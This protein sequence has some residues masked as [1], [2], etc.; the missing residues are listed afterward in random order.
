[1]NR[2]KAMMMGMLT[3]TLIGLTTTALAAA[4]WLFLA[5]RLNAPGHW[6]GT[7]TITLLSFSL[8]QGLVIGGLNGSLCPA[9][10]NR[11]LV[12]VSVLL[13][14]ALGAI[15]VMVSG[16]GNQSL[17]PVAIY[18]LAFINGGVT[19]VASLLM[20]HRTARSDEGNLL[21]S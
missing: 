11:E 19:A 12:A 21:I 9:L 7:V 5:G 15:R 1:M 10:G 4:A 8:L 18:G 3:G 6:D 16:F 13:S 14:L 2:I 17:L 20:L